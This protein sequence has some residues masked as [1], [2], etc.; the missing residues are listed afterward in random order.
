MLKDASTRYTVAFLTL[1]VVSALLYPA[2]NSGA[3]AV[4]WGLLALAVLTTGMILVVK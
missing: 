2:A 3:S 4:V 1:C